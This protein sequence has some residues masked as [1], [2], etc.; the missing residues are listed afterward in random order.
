MGVSSMILDDADY[1]EIAERVATIL[2]DR[3][4]RPEDGRDWL[5]VQQASDAWGV[6]TERR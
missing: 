4:P 1:Q 2:A 3:Y 5:S 6:L